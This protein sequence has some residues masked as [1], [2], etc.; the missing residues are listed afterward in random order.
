MGDSDAT[1]RY[2]VNERNMAQVRP[3]PVYPHRRGRKARA[4]AVPSGEL[5]S[6]LSASVLK[7]LNLLTCFEQDGEELGIKDLERRL[8]MH[9]STVHRFA[10]TLCSAGF[11]SQSSDSGRYRLGLRIVELS[12]VVMNGIPLR[13]LAL[14][15]LAT[16]AV[17]SGANANLGILW[18]DAVLY[19]ARVPSPRIQ[20]TYF[21][22]GRKAGLHC[23]ALGK[24]LLAFLTRDAQAAILNRLDLRQY[25]P[26]TIT[27]SD[28]LFEH[29]ENVRQRGFATDREEFMVGSH[30]IAGP[31]RGAGG[32]VIGAISLSTTLLD[33][34]YEQL[35][36]RLP[37]LLEAVRATSYSMGSHMP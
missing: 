21:H 24:I 4:D 3:R 13:R 25:T 35:L 20:D 18:E 12:R 32:E 29:L 1:P 31:V 19:L 15:H 34:T 8:G 23:T 26:N 2:P 5:R 33:M 14:P 10:T 27:R 17:K 9:A 28:M 22:P 7:A 11:L 6:H 36:D 30:C 16:L 37:D